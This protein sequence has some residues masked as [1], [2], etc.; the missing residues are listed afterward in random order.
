MNIPIYTQPQIRRMLLAQESSLA[1][2]EGVLHK[3]HQLSYQLGINE[4]L[5]L[6]Y[7]D[8]PPRLLRGAAELCQRVGMRLGAPLPLE[9][10]YQTTR[11]TNLPFLIV[12]GPVKG[13]L[14]EV[15]A[16]HY[17]K[18]P[19][20][21]LFDYAQKSVLIGSAQ[22]GEYL[23]P[24]QPR[25]DTL[26]CYVETHIPATDALLRAL[27]PVV[28]YCEALTAPACSAQTKPTGALAEQPI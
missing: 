11:G 12:P 26:P 15:L 19:L 4:V 23:M 2:N 17:D 24:T 14:N 27:G 3:L 18:A 10:L 8:E 9:A 28:C 13:T 5:V 7:P 6:A 21:T 22:L 20:S 1:A 16:R 25:P